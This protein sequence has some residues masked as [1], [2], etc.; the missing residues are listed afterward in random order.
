MFISV[1]LPDPDAPISATSSPRLI[2]NEIPFSTGTSTSPKWYVLRM[3]S[4][5]MSSIAVT[6]L[7]GILCCVSA[8][9]AGR[10]ERII[11][12]GAGGRC[13]ACLAN[14]DLVAFLDVAARDFGERHVALASADIDRPYGRRSR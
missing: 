13:L 10:P 2:V 11:Y 4:R 14:D 9:E 7:T 8:A 12:V 5:R 1:L 6:C 3:S